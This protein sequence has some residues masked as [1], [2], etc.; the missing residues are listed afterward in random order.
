[1]SFSSGLLSPPPFLSVIHHCFTGPSAG[2]D[3]LG[4]QGG[5]AIGPQAR[6]L[7]ATLYIR[8]V[9]GLGKI[10]GLKSS[11]HGLER[12]GIQLVLANFNVRK[13]NTC[14]TIFVPPCSIYEA[15]FCSNHRS[16]V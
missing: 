6:R 8:N 12:F 7:L 9:S 5:D 16:F 1:M 3:P 14:G 13:Q 11:E 15:S 4:L 10:D 2:G